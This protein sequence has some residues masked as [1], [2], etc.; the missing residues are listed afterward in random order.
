ML[1]LF[2]SVSIIAALP[3]YA[4]AIL[5]I[6]PSILSTT[7]R[8]DG[9]ALVTYTVTNNTTAAINGITINA[10]Y[11]SNAIPADLKIQNNKCANTT[12]AAAAS[13]TFQALMLGNNQ[14]NNFSIRPQVCAYNGAECS[15]ATASN[16][17]HVTVNSIDTPVR[18]YVN[19]FSTEQY[20]IRNELLPI[21]VADNTP[22]TAISNFGVINNLLPVG[23]A[24][25]TDGTKVFAAVQNSVKVIDSTTDPISV[26]DQITVGTRPT[27][28]AVAPNS[29]TVYAANSVSDTVSVIDTAS[30]TVI[31][32]LSVGENPNG[33]AVMP[34]GSKVYVANKDDDSVSVIHTV[35]NS[36]TLISDTHPNPLGV[37][38]SPDGTKVYVT[39]TRILARGF[40]DII[41]A[42]TNTIT[43]T[44]ALPIGAVPR[45]V[46]VSPNGS[47]VYVADYA[48]AR[49]AV[50]NSS[51]NSLT[52]IDNV[53][54]N[55]IGVA[56]DPIGNTLY[57]TLSGSNNVTSINT[58]TLEITNIGVNGS[59]ATFGNFIG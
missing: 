24:V 35:D 21:T 23:V 13:C 42:S 11:Q 41:D 47:K 56:L 15:V 6:V 39:C 9:D 33:I 25:S 16:A 36:V 55:P 18:A 2:T 20:N 37:A 46:V 40:V 19:V 17:L 58:A 43:D 5:N 1:G 54:L 45:G 28:V 3:C 30:D 34:D 48:N 50:I 14:T 38:I 10:A 52:F 32:T 57:V 59:Q 22:G 26:I 49:V 31:A 51:D 53:G 12:V 7:L 27:G 8:S 44:I 4:T 29:S